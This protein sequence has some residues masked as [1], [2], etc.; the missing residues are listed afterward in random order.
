MSRRSTVV[1]TLVLVLLA[2]TLVPVSA[3]PSVDW[4]T[5]PGT[6]A[7]ALAQ[8][9]GVR[10][11]IDAVE[12]D[13]IRSKHTPGYLVIHESFDSHDRIA[14]VTHPSPLLRLTQTI[15]VQGVMATLPRSGRR[16]IVRAQIVGYCDSSGRLLRWGPV[17]KGLLEPIAWRWKV[18]LT[19]AAAVGQSGMGIAEWTP[20]EDPDPNPG[21][22]PTL[23]ETVAEI[24]PPNTV[25]EDG[26]LVELQAKPIVAS[27]SETIDSQEYHYIDIQDDG[28]S[29]T[30]R[31]YVDSEV[32]AG[33]LNSVTGQVQDG[34]ICVNDGPGYDPQLY[35][36]IL[37]APEAESIPYAQTLQDDATTTITGRIVTA[38]RSD[39]PGALYVAE[40]L[41][42]PD[43]PVWQWGGMRVRYTG[44]PSTEPVRGNV[45][46]IGGSLGIGT[47]GEREITATSITVTGS[48]PVPSPI[49]MQTKALGGGNLNTETPG[50]NY[51]EACYGL[52]N[53]GMLVKVLGKVTASEP[54]AKYFCVDDGG[55][56]N[57]GSAAPV[58]VTWDWPSK[59]AI[60]PPNVG[61]YVSVAG[62]S[63]SE[64]HDTGPPIHYS[65]ALRVRRQ[66][67][68]IAVDPAVAITSPYGTAWHKN[69]NA[70]ILVSGT[71]TEGWS[72]VVS[73]HVSINSGTWQTATYNSSAHT[74]SY[75]WPNPASA[76][77][78]FTVRAT[79][80]AGHTGQASVTVTI[81]SL[82]VKFVSPSGNDSNNGSTW[83]LAKRNVG[84]GMGEASANN[85]VW[86]AA[87]TYYTDTISL[88]SSV[89]LYGGFAG[90]E[91]CREQR[92]W[93]TKPTV[94]DGQRSVRVVTAENVTSMAIDGFTLQ[95]GSTDIGGGLNCSNAT[96][97]VSHNT[98]R[99]CKATFGGGGLYLSGAAPTVADNF[100][101]ANSVVVGYN[102]YGGGICY[103]GATGGEIVNNTVVANG[104]DSGGGMYVSGS[105]SV[106]N[107][108]VANNSCGGIQVDGGAPT[109]LKNYVYD[110]AGSQYSGIAVP[111]T[112]V[113]P[114]GD[115]GFFN[116]YTGD[117]HILS[118][119]PC[120]DAGSN[121]AVQSDVDIDRQVRIYGGTVDVGADE[122]SGADPMALTPLIIRV[123][124]GGNNSNDGS[125]WALAKSTLSSAISSASASGST[126]VWVAGGT[127]H[128]AISVPSDVRL[129]GGF[130]GSETD[131]SQRDWGVNLTSIDASG[132]NASTVTI[133]GSFFAQIDG[134]TIRGGAGAFGGGV[135]CTNAL[136]TV[137]HNTIT[138]CSSTGHGGGIACDNS[139]ATL[140]GNVIFGNTSVTGGG[141][142]YWSNTRP[143]GEILNNTIVANNSAA[144]S[145]GNTVN[146]FNNIVAYNGGGIYTT[147]APS[148]F[149]KNDVYGNTGS[150]YGGLITTRPST[151]LVSVDPLFVDKDNADYHVWWSSPCK[152]AGYD[153]VVLPDTH[154]IDA[155]PRRN[156]PIDIGADETTECMRFRLTITSEPAYAPIGDPVTV[157]AHVVDVVTNQAAVGCR[158][159]ISIDA[160]EI[161]SISPDGHVNQPPTS[162]YGMTNAGGE[163]EAVIRR[164]DAGF[165]HANATIMRC[166]KTVAR[167]TRIGF[168][169]TATPVDIFFCLDC[170]GS[171]WGNGDDH[172]AQPSVKAFL[173]EMSSTYGIQFRVGGV[174]F[175]GPSI[176]WYDAVDSFDRDG[177]GNLTQVAFRSLGVFQNLAGI[178][179]WIENGYSPDGCDPYELQLDALHYAALDVNAYASSSRKYIV[180]ITDNK[181]HNHEGGSTVWKDDVR[182][183]LIATGCPVYISL[184]NDAFHNDY[185]QLIVNGGAFDPANSSGTDQSG[186]WKFPLTE[187]RSRILSE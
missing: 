181:Y 175:N 2:F 12:I 130:A 37:S 73:V 176:C 113:A 9:D 167:A 100:I 169:S 153:A 87:S 125:T 71:V 115:P 38:D 8:P 133:D 90:T 147:W 5:R 48:G 165:V 152:D 103:E 1:S 13:K 88:K 83:A 156:G 185:T 179:Q 55:R 95:N 77:H 105:P 170:T 97:I 178:T 127:Y 46:T 107:N 76:T 168:F 23:Y 7:Y 121:S 104:A 112:D 50:I 108:I 110:N 52:Y 30:I 163:V 27:G 136:C 64:R 128:E 49:G 109:F 122:W 33:R 57:S 59:P 3:S 132:L 145:V 151:D 19:V 155:E 79:D 171:M 44:T 149:Q 74:W 11:T 117:F 102:G 17:I 96:G 187:L 6:I 138:G 123:K 93:K 41:A 111:G 61:T 60:N 16:V 85:E 45:V 148:V 126:E 172:G 154:D 158:A 134:F 182:N 119:S 106:S 129:Y 25:P 82:T 35:E 98:I 75:I 116:R 65:R 70:A 80:S 29:S 54:S 39:F 135:R 143:G 67:D 15:D 63:G 164:L 150:Q 26:S 131:R 183:D 144:I 162:G 146:I 56:L 72:P 66:D 36:G 31:A 28:G 142:I 18:D 78:T 4:F 184:W 141:G 84:A 21:P 40:C 10:V 22:P 81:Q 118:F 42:I 69:G 124:P 89:G 137:N 140:A 34:A 159:D 51:P 139:T 86:V 174:K 160:G 53:K 101:V 120:R 58:K 157:T 114:A 32:T 20:P 47:D 173:T 94:L 186:N 177:N 99:G 166:D 92:N 91:T 24:T 43:G 180:L 68:V 14:V 161:V 62:I